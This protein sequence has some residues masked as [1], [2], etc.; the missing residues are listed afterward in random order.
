MVIPFLNLC[1]P[2]NIYAFTLE[3]LFDF[4]YNSGVI[5][6]LSLY[7]GRGWDPNYVYRDTNY[8]SQSII[9]IT[10]ISNLKYIIF[11][12]RVGLTMI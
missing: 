5:A 1:M 6:I 10:S 2:E 4:L 12:K 11:M 3:Q 7:F 9:C 8:I